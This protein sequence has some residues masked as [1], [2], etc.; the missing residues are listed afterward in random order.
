MIKIFYSTSTETLINALIDQINQNTKEP[1]EK[2]TIIVPNNNISKYI[3]LY[4]SKKEGIAFNINFSY[5]ENILIEMLLNLIGSKTENSDIEFLHNKKNSIL[6]TILINNLIYNNID[7]NEL[8]EIKKYVA[9]SNKREKSKKIWQISEK[10]A[11]LFREYEYKRA[12]MI[13]KWLQNK[14]F[15][16]NVKTEDFQRYIYFK[17]FNREN[18][19]IKLLDK[20]YITL[21][22]LFNV[23]KTKEKKILEKKETVNIF[24]L[25]NISNLHYQVIEYLNDFHN[26]NF[27][28]LDIS[29]KYANKTSNISK[30]FSLKDENF[31]QINSIIKSKEFIPLEKNQDKENSLLNITK[32]NLL[33]DTLFKSTNKTEND[34]SIR[35]FSASSISREVETVINSITYNIKNNPDLKLNDIAILVPNIEK[36]KSH[37]IFNFEKNKFLKFNLT[38]SSALEDSN[39][40]K[41]VIALLNI[42]ND[43][44]TR[45]NCFSLFYNECFQ[46]KIKLTNDQINSWLKL[47]EKANIY[48]NINNDSVFSFRKGIRRLLLG[49][50]ME[51]EE[52]TFN[53]YIENI[54]Y[55]EAIADEVEIDKFITVIVELNKVIYEINQSANHSILITKILELLD[56]Y[57]AVDW[58]DSFELTVQNSLKEAL[59]Q[60]A[61]YI[62]K[63]ENTNITLDTIIEYI[64]SVLKSIGSSKGS[65]LLNAINV[66]QLFPMRPIP[67]KIIYILGLNESDFPGN[68][69]SSFLNLTNLETRLGD[70]KT[71]DI[72]LFSF[73]EIIIASKEKLYLSYIDKDIEKDADLYPS[74]VINNLLNFIN[75]NILKDDKLE[76]VTTPLNSESLIFLEKQKYPDI[77]CNTNLNDRVYMIRRALK[78]GY[79]LNNKL[80][81]KMENI[82]N[83]YTFFISDKQVINYKDK[84]NILITID[85]LTKFLENPIEY[86]INKELDIYDETRI[87]ISEIED[88]PFF[89]TPILRWDVENKFFEKI[90]EEKKFD[91]TLL[92]YVKELYTFNSLKGK[93]PEKEFGF[94]QM[95]ELENQTKNKFIKSTFFNFLNELK[96]YDFF[97]KKN[98]EENKLPCINFTFNEITNKNIEI[99]GCIDYLFIKNSSYRTV[100][101]TSSNDIK[102]KYFIKYFL[103]YLFLLYN[104]YNITDF[105]LTII[106][107]KKDSEILNFNFD[108]Y[109]KDF[110]KEYLKNLITDYLNYEKAFDNVPIEIIDKELISEIN[111]ID[112]KKYKNLFTDKLNKQID[113]DFTAFKTSETVMLLK[114]NKIPDNVKDIIEKR[115]FPILKK[116]FLK[117]D[118]DD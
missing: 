114:E 22:E 60:F 117:E 86:T 14:N 78:Y 12:D 61:E 31:K 18:G 20:K 73:S 13:E 67:F 112:D 27:Y 76:I 6:L 30:I 38:D 47:T 10:L 2:Q 21:S 80:K 50:I 92:N 85:M 19:Y 9:N 23:V 62:E 42:L 104:N 36:Y 98:S 11:S 41:A 35:I 99:T 69:D 7:N 4:I 107:N 116:K 3:S 1:F 33:D 106:S 68:N 25:S 82:K 49:K 64:K 29:G 108:T 71:T 72:N 44:L 77:I 100:H 51:S 87:D 118:N 65:Y 113:N 52:E 55:N 58:D 32:K 28:L 15:Y 103:Y 111:K 91:E 115:L 96:E 83:T 109:H 40:G 37:I 101:L 57:L 24:S 45:K 84:E 74:S 70:L 105:S 81:E 97:S 75:E 94:L 17:L 89:I 102:N 54:P 95:L 34:G 66:S 90:I 63:L 110:A 5:L 59:L 93:A 39:Y 16:Q 53:S 56:Q 88:E 26:F 43:N 46:K 8:L 48:N 79:Q